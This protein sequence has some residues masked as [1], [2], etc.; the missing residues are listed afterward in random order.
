M[1]ASAAVN[2]G[3][4]F[5]RPRL[6]S[7]LTCTPSSSPAAAAAASSRYALRRVRVRSAATKPAKSPGMLHQLPV[8]VV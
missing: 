7:G 3:F 4:S 2:T 5:Y 1:I 8:R 6:P